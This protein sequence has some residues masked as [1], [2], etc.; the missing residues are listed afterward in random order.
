MVIVWGSAEAQPGKV[1][2]LLRISL[3]H[4][5][6][7]RTEPGCLQHGVHIDAEN[8]N[9]LVFFEQWQDRAALQ[10]HFEVPESGGFVQQA[11]TLCV[12]PP[13]LKIFESEP[14]D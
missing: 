1:E 13:E 3:E 10:T 4:V 11:M 7:S 5:A 12:G 8:P 6:R 14:I 9:R 2:E